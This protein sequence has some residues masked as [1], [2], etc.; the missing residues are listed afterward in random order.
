MLRVVEFSK[1][2]FVGHGREVSAEAPNCSS[3]KVAMNSH[4]RKL[5]RLTGETKCEQRADGRLSNLVELG[6]ASS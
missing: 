2:L 3:V 4:V 6:R 5:S 1:D